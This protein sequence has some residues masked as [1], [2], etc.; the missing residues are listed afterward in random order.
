MPSTW[1][2][3]V[4]QRH[5]RLPRAGHAQLVRGCTTGKQPGGSR[6]I[7]LQGDLFDQPGVALWRPA[8][9]W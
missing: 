1:G 6:D 5:A 4:R 7:T 9:S 2:P 3:E 8:S